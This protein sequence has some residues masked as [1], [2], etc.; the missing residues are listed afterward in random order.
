LADIGTKDIKTFL[1]QGLITGNPG[2]LLSCAVE[3]GDIKF[4][5][6]GENTIGNGIKNG[7]KILVTVFAV[8]C[9]YFFE[10]Q[11]CDLLPSLICNLSKLAKIMDYYIAK[12]Q[13]I[14]T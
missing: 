7:F 3:I 6:D 10:A 9:G 5:V 13:S 4:K 12:M 1:P 11:I 14:A 8:V 2:N